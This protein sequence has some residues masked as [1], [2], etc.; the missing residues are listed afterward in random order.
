MK[1]VLL[2][3]KL[4]Q[5]RHWCFWRLE[6]E[7]LLYG[8]KISILV[9][10]PSLVGNRLSQH[11]TTPCT[12]HMSFCIQRIC[13]ATHTAYSPI[14]FSSSCFFQIVLFTVYIF[15][16]ILF[17]LLYF[18]HAFF[19][20]PLFNNISMSWLS[21]LPI[22]L[23]PSLFMVQSSSPTYFAVWQFQV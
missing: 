19:L 12:I 9:T 20:Q 17:I 1:K 21:C 7:N 14:L 8:T 6:T 10:I 3:Q 22:L 23:T 2:T 15:S 5:S 18:F 11:P 16:P 13:C 4:T